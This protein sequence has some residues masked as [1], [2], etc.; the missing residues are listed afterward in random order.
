MKMNRTIKLLLIS[1]VFA[2][3]GFGLIEPILAIFIKDNLVGGTIFAAGLA[4]GVYLIVKSVIQLPFSHYVDKHG[5]KIR[6]LIIGS[7]INLVVPFLY[8]YADHVNYIYA[9]QVLLG[10]GGGLAYPCWLGLWSVNLDKNHESFEWS[11][12]STLTSL[13]T[14]LAGIGGAVIAEFVGFKVTFILVG[15]LAMFGYSL[16]FLLQKESDTKK[17]NLIIPFK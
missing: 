16:L 6:W 10:I 17:N 8:I 5:H 1:D 7:L 4:S 14:A 3:T 11:L 9:A 2:I 13:G 15:V 12:Y